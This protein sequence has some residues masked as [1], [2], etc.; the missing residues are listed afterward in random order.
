MKTV[1]KNLYVFSLVL[2]YVFAYSGIGVHRC[3]I[4]NTIDFIV[5]SDELSHTCQAVYHCNHKHISS[6][7]HGHIHTLCHSCTDACENTTHF[8]QSDCCSVSFYVL[9]DS[10][11]SYESGTKVYLPDSIVYFSNLEL[12]IASKVNSNYVVNT[13]LYKSVSYQAL[14]SVWTL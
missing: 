13:E 10:Q 8:H 14:F 11:N 12:G 6:D 2:L 1:F 7:Q 5:E 9:T 4:D 3:S